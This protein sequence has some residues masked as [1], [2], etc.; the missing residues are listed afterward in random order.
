[1]NA[2]D[3]TL[4]FPLRPGA[5]SLMARI[6]SFSARMFLPGGVRIVAVA[7]LHATPPAPET[8]DFLA[9]MEVERRAIPTPLLF[10]HNI[11]ALLK[12]DAAA[13]E[14]DTG[15][16]L[17]LNPN[18]L[19]LHRTDLADLPDPARGFSACR[20]FRRTLFEGDTARAL[21]TFAARRFGIPVAADGDGVGFET[22]NSG[23][24]LFSRDAALPGQWGRVAAEFLAS[25]IGGDDVAGEAD[26]LALG[27]LAAR[28][29]AGFTRL[30]PH[31]NMLARDAGHATLA[32]YFGLAEL[33]RSLRLREVLLSLA[34]AADERG[35]NL[36]GEIEPRDIRQLAR[37]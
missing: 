2:E 29:G 27:V 33:I 32:Q 20:T 10:R 21:T 3:L 12:V 34:E 4:V 24:V 1:M 31:Y 16:V 37:P 22:C 8:L 15:R 18:C 13:A 6:L 9:E 30:P 23:V 5:G 19:F 35:L 26:Q 14:Y 11:G 7:P 28:A 36:L 25:K 17:L